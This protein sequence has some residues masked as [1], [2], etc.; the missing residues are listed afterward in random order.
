MFVCFSSPE[1]KALGDLIGW[2]PSSVHTYKHEYHF[3]QL[4]NQDQISSEASLGLEI[5]C[6]RFWA[7]SEYNFGFHGN[8]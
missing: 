4:L 8:R 6:I 3:D 5:D 2:R 1:P 7:R